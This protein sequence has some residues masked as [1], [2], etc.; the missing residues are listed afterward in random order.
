MCKLFDLFLKVLRASR[1]NQNT[2]I[3]C[4]KMARIRIKYGQ[5]EIEIESKDFYVDNHS[6]NEVVN[7][8]A[9][10]VKDQNTSPLQYDHSYSQSSQSTECLNM[11][12]DAEIHEPEFT[13]PTFLDKK[14]LRN[15]IKVLIEDSFFDQPRTVSEVVSQLHEY[16][17]TAVPLDVSK[18][19][20]DM[21]FSYQLQKELREKR[22]YYSV[23]S[24]LEVN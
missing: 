11:L 24:M 16:G 13:K 3:E 2:K 22:S 18:M 4:Y 12:E 10:F 6:I 9:F 23:A 1:I 15:K 7:N 20:T 8:L 19:L 14:Q 5:N 17:W 21:A